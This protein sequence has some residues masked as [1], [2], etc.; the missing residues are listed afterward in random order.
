[1]CSGAKHASDLVSAVTVA[2]TVSVGSSRSM[3]SQTLRL[4][5]ASRIARSWAC[6]LA[7]RWAARST[8][9]VDD[10]PGLDDF[11]FFAGRSGL[12]GP[13]KGCFQAARIVA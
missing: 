8:P 3:R 12:I 7:L 10:K 2:S 9:D 4:R 5:N 11:D 1:M 13:E 6:A